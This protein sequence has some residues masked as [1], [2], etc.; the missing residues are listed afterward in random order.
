MNVVLP[1]WTERNGTG[2]RAFATKPQKHGRAGVRDTHG[3]G[4]GCDHS[5]GGAAARNARCAWEISVQCPEIR[6]N[7]PP[8]SVPVQN[9]WEVQ[10]TSIFIN[11]PS[12]GEGKLQC[13]N[14]T[15][16]IYNFH[17]KYFGV[18]LCPETWP[19]AL[20]PRVV[21][22]ARQETRARLGQGARGHNSGWPVAF[23]LTAPGTSGRRNPHS[24]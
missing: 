19:G 2:A 6:E 14:S 4:P 8:G 21:H 22:S 15:R 12:P 23:I 18:P 7:A 5:H 17:T 9:E 20:S 13:A 24:F 11:F 3:G 10:F 16:E 1:V